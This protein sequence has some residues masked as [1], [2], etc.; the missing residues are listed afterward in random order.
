MKIPLMTET[1]LKAKATIKTKSYQTMEASKMRMEICTIQERY[2]YPINSC[3]HSPSC[4]CAR[5]NR[6]TTDT[7]ISV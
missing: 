5:D 4:N 7:C 1:M 2:H 3:G 6:G